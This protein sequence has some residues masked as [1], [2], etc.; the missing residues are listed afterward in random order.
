MKQYLPFWIAFLVMTAMTSSGQ[1]T[2]FSGQVWDSS[3]HGLARGTHI[4]LFKNDTTVFSNEAGWF[5][6]P[7]K[8]SRND[9]AVIS[10]PALGMTKI[11]FCF[12]DDE[13]VEFNVR[14]PKSCKGL[15][16]TNICPKCNSASDVIPIEYGLPTTEMRKSSKRGLTV[17]GGCFVD[18]CAPHH[19]CKK[20]NFKF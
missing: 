7:L 5:K 18:D 2:F 12:I 13:V 19:F 15:A 16:T 3:G 4:K 11:Y 8:K 9:T 17:L 1:T 14:L 20:D 10:H 6:V